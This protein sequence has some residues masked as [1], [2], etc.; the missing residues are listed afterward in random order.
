[1]QQ[2]KEP[3]SSNESIVWQRRQKRLKT[4][5]G[6]VARMQLLVP[7][8]N[9]LGQE[10]IRRHLQLVVGLARGEAFL[11]NVVVVY[12]GSSVFIIRW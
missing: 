9:E 2:H 3:F 1:M 8:D 6:N 5:F 12:I 7:H 11:K 10:P 4:L